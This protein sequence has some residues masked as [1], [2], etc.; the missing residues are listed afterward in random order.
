MPRRQTREIPRW[1]RGKGRQPQV[2]QQIV[3]IRGRHARDLIRQMETRQA[4]QSGQQ[5]GKAPN[6]AAPAND[7]LAR[8]GAWSR[9]RQM[10][11]LAWGAG[12]PVAGAI[13]H[14]APHPALSGSLGGIIAAVLLILFTR[15]LSAFARR[16]CDAAAF[17]TLAWLPALAIGGLGA[18]V[19]ALL[20]ITVAVTSGTWW[21]HYGHRPHPQPEPEPDTTSDQA[22]WERLAARRKWSARLT[23]PETIPGGGIKWQIETDGIETHIGNIMSEPRAIAAAYG[24]AQTEAYVEPH[25]TGIESKGVFTR[26]RSGTLQAT[27][28]WDGNGFDSRGIARIGRYADGQPCRIRAWVPMD[29]T[30]HGLIAGT[31]GAGKSELLNLLLWLAVSSPV[32]IVP[33]I[34]D[35]QNGQSLPQWRGRVPY[36]A[37]VEECARMMHGLNAGMMDRSRR[38]ASMTW[39]D[40]GHKAK[41]M[42]F[43]DARLSALPVV[44][45]IID[46][47]PL[48]L[49]GDGNAK[50][51]ADM[52]RL[53]AQGAK[54]DRKTGGSKWVV[55]QV[56]SLAEFGDQ[57]LRSM[58]VGGNVIG[59]RT[60]DRVSGGMI[61]LDADPSALPKY[62]PD[63]E[64][65]Q[66]IGYAVTL[67]NRQAPMRTDLVPSRMRHQ[68][69]E[70]PQLEDE[71][72]E[73]MDREMSRHTPLPNVAPLIAASQSEQPADDG[74]EGRRCVDAVWQVLRASGGEMERGE[75]IAAAAKVATEEWGREKAWSIRSVTNALGDLAGGKDPDRP[76]IKPRDG[77]YEALAPRGETT[78]ADHAPEEA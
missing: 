29:G 26:L 69:A 65:T 55:A 13:A 23:S 32:P 64:P 52:V 77:V 38:L 71:F 10:P 59:L 68:K 5:A 57:T 4:A 48:L 35:P 75:I 17:L 3:Q 58:L 6:P 63:G 39:D 45:P 54:L 30:R 42:Q 41:G 53:T 76:V 1:R 60:G 73:A 34:L 7:V 24:K 66:G 67:D 20:A 8:T 49:S 31:S 40:D 15:H 51:A 44:M 14:A 78:S 56:P 18:P 2:P 22:I 61:G 9:R 16:W 46:E 21:R 37:G 11:P 25:P 70:V 50:L 36:A 28:E 27:E 72:L 33:L 74:P 19:P 43:F 12:L 47:A 62:F